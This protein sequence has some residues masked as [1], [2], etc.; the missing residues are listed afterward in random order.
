MGLALGA[1]VSSYGHDSPADVI[2][3]LTK[4]I[5]SKGEIPSLLLQRSYKYRAMG[6]HEAAERGLIRLTEVGPDDTAACGELARARWV[7]NDV[8]GAE[9]AIRAGLEIAAPEVERAELLALRAEFSESKGEQ[10][11]A[12]RHCKAALK[13]RSGELD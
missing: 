12:L 3:S 7:Q 1:S 5:E 6:E 2:E 11:G 9:A 10:R 8:E 4:H 13:A